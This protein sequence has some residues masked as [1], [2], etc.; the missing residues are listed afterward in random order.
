MVGWVFF[1]ATTFGHAASFVAAMF[2]LGSDGAVEYVPAIYLQTDV[3]LALIAGAIS[4]APLLTWLRRVRPGDLAAA[5]RRPALAQ[6]LEAVF[7]GASVAAHAVL[8]L[9]STTMLAAGTYNPF[10]YFRF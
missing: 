6:A 1:R 2:G 7:A 8:L 5:L 10:I 4:S 9:A 3:V